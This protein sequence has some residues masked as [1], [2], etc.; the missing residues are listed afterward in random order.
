MIANYRN[1]FVWDIM[2]RDPYIRAGLERA[3]FTGGWL[4]AGK[5]KPAK[6]AAEAGKDAD[7]CTDE[8]PARLRPPLKPPQQRT[9]PAPWQDRQHPPSPPQATPPAAP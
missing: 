3:G 7:T 4:D 5:D 1:E 9:T 2:R 6:D 8:S